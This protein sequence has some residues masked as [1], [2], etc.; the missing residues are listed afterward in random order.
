MYQYGLLIV[1]NV[2][3]YI[4]IFIIGEMIYMGTPCKIFTIFLKSKAVFINKA[5]FF[6]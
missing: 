4:K 1:T 6:K 2:P 3:Y 5:Y